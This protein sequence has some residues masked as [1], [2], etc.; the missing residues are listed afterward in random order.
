MPRILK[1]KL[2]SG[3]SAGWQVESMEL[4][5]VHGVVTI[6]ILTIAAELRTDTPESRQP[7]V[8]EDE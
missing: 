5:Q 4:R 3:K 7:K 6:S 8:K 2:E 1:N